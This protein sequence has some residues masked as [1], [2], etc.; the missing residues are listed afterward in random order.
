MRK[1]LKPVRRSQNPL[2]LWRP[3]NSLLRGLEVK[4]QRILQGFPR[5]RPMNGKWAAAKIAAALALAFS[6]PA[7]ASDLHSRPIIP[8]QPLSV[9][10]GFYGGA[11]FGAA[12][13]G[14]NLTVGSGASFSTDPSGVLGGIQFGYN[15]LF[16]PNWLVGLEIEFDWTSGQGTGSFVTPNT[17]GTFTSNHNWYDIVAGRLGYTTGNLFYY[18][19]GGGAWMNADYRMVT[20]GAISGIF[21]T[22]STRGG[23]MIGAGAEYS[24]TPQW[25]AKFEYAFLDFSDGNFFGATA[26]TQ[27]HEI[28]VG[29][30]YH[31]APGTLV[32]G[33]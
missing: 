29:V 25:S 22:N 19:K 9:W 33:F 2:F 3:G 26:S 18:V 14:E 32:A 4:C 21:A 5:S 16:S 30:N 28:K 8:A 6:V 1:G 27:V 17:A 13:P 7:G 24:V 11:N 23:M 15:Y 12:F 31:L 20:A 10:S